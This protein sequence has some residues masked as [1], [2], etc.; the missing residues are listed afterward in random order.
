VSKRVS[1]DILRAQIVFKCDLW[2]NNHAG[3]LVSNMTPILGC[4]VSTRQ[5]DLGII[6]SDRRH[7]PQ[8]QQHQAHLEA[9]TVGSARTRLTLNLFDKF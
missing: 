2:G 6:L 1:V 8:Q 7:H 3:P 4:K 9:R 5:R